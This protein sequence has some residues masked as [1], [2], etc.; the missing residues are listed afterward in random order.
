MEALVQRYL[1]ESKLM[2]S[3]KHPNITKFIGLCFLPDTQNLPLIVMEQLEMSLDEHL[4]NPSVPLLNKYSILVDVASGLLYL[5]TRTPQVIH[6]D[7]T[8]KNVLLSFSPS[9]VAKITDMGNARIVNMQ[10]GQVVKTLTHQLGTK[11][12]MPP[13]ALDRKH[14]YGPSLDIFSFGHLALYVLIQVTTAEP[15][16]REVA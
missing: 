4:H 9:L 6:R 11:D 15:V 14:R 16:V 12:Y 5:H 10:P 13:E 3:L 7:L 8:S 2:H 1:K